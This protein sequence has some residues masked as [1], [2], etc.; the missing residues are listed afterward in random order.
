MTDAA[1]F[2]HVAAQQITEQHQF[3][4]GV[5]EQWQT[6]FFWLV[7]HILS[8]GET[9][10]AA[11]GVQAYR[12]RANQG[13]GVQTVTTQIAEDRERVEKFQRE[14][15]ESHEGGELTLRRHGMKPAPAGACADPVQASVPGQVGEHLNYCAIAVGQWNLM[16]SRPWT[17]GDVVASRA[18]AL[19]FAVMPTVEIAAEKARHAFPVQIKA[20]VELAIFNARLV[21]HFKQA[22]R[23]FI[24]L[25]A[26]VFELHRRRVFHAAALIESLIVSRTDQTVGPLGDVLRGVI[27]QQ[28]T[29]DQRRFT[30][31]FSRQ[32]VKHQH[33][34]TEPPSADRKALA[35][36]G[37]RVWAKQPRLQGIAVVHRDFGQ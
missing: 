35:V 22:G 32:I 12:V 30:D 27:F 26:T 1:Q 7:S 29:S 14:F 25:E 36:G 3:G 33:L 10:F 28:Q 11:I 15:V 16:Q 9:F 2:G 24:D 5:A 20:L 34:P 17:I 13:Q 37:K 23:R 6:V 4:G 21:L 31:R 19:G 18:C 8:R